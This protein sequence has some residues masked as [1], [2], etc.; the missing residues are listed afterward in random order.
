MY[1]TNEIIERKKMHQ[2][3]LYVLL[4]LAL[5]GCNAQKQSAPEPTE[6]SQ[7][8]QINKPNDSLKLSEDEIKQR[9]EIIEK[10]RREGRIVAPLTHIQLRAFPLRPMPS[11][12][13]FRAER[14]S[15]RTPPLHTFHIIC[16]SLF[17]YIRIITKDG[18]IQALPCKEAQ[19]QRIRSR[20][21]ADSIIYDTQLILPVHTDTKLILHTVR[22]LLS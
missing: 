16:K 21:G 18:R 3:G 12:H 19:A 1:D 8:P 14:R 20:M 10:L 2:Y 13:S 9:K 11:R 15:R 6:V 22:K 17:S 4:G 5:M 7:Q